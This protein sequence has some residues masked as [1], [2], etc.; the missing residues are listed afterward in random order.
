MLKNN[1]RDRVLT[2]RHSLPWPRGNYDLW[3]NNSNLGTGTKL[4]ESSKNK[5][6]IKKEKEIIPFNFIPRPK[7]LARDQKSQKWM[8]VLK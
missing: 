3:R 4:K 7:E 1:Y 2:L 6:R 8:Y 5:N